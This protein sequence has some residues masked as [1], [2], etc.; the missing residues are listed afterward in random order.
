MNSV[1]PAPD[2]N[3]VADENLA[4]QENPAP[5]ENPV[6]EENPVETPPREQRTFRNPCCCRT[7][8]LTALVMAILD[9]CVRNFSKPEEVH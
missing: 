2:E 5:A 8:R 9:I 1:A 4:P 3:P 6:P 7:F